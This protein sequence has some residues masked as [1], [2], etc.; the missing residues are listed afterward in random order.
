MLH[1]RILNNLPDKDLGVLIFSLLCTD[2]QCINSRTFSVFLVTV[3]IF[4]F[5]YNLLGISQAA[6]KCW[7]ALTSELVLNWGVIWTVVFEFAILNKSFI[8]LC[9]KWIQTASDPHC[10]GVFVLK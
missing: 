3:Q 2:G 4:T 1:I 6:Y 7:K 5:V 9:I 10:C 8:Y